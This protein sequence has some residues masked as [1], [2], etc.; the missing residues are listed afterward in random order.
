M[1]PTAVV[2]LVVAAVASATLLRPIRCERRAADD[3]RARPGARASARRLPRRRADRRLRR[4]H[5]RRR[6]GAIAALRRRDRSPPVAVRTARPGPARARAERRRGRLALLA[7][8]GRRVGGAQRPR[9]DRPGCD[10]QAERQLVQVPVEPQ[11]GG[12]GAHLGDPEG[13]ELG[14][15]GGD[16]HRRRLRGLP[17]PEHGAAV[18]QGARLGRHALR[19]RLRLLQRRRPP[20]RRRGPRNPRGLDDRRRHEQHHRRGRARLR[21]ARSCR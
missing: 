11:A 12:R 3:G 21:R 14:G 1:R 7:H 16:R 19:D 6:D 20:E 15:G 4:G 18:P 9:L 8:A 2:A 17:R 13:Q 5:E 10:V